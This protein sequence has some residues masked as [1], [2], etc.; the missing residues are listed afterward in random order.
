MTQTERVVAFDLLRNFFELFGHVGMWGPGVGLI[1]ILLAT[2]AASGDR[3]V[4][5]WRHVFLMYFEA[6][7]L[8]IPLLVLNWAI[9][10]GPPLS[11]APSTVGQ[12]VLGI[13]AGIYEELVFRLILISVVMMI[14]VD[15]LRLGRTR[16]ALAAVVL[17]S[18]VFAAH[19]H[20]PIGMEPFELTRFLFRSIAGI[21]LALIFWYRGYG[22]AAGCHAAYNAT[23]VITGTLPA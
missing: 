15:L 7:A 4:I 10:L 13:G 14:G 9:P 22:S 17:S 18:L 5:H 3:W 19:H 12:L 8:A 6:T 16:V 11:L 21:Y 23:L 2:H 1:V 20:Q